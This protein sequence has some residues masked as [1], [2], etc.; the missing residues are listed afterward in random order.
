MKNKTKKITNDDIANAI[1]GNGN[2]AVLET[3]KKTKSNLQ[4]SPPGFLRQ[5]KVLLHNDDKNT[6]QYAFESLLE[7][8]PLKENEA[9][10]CIKEVEESGVGLVLTTHKERAELYQEQLESKGLVSTIEPD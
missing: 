5:W 9:K 6:K 7:V 2:V 3:E 8:T 4:K 1:T 10:V